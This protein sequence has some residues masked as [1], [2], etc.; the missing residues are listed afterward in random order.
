MADASHELRSP[1]AN[2]RAAIEVALTY[3]DSRPW[4]EVVSEVHAQT[5]RISRL[6]EDLLVLARARLGSWD[7][8]TKRSIWRR[9]RTGWPMTTERQHG[10]YG[11]SSAGSTR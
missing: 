9:L 11:Y 7:V 6:V 3:P 4:P 1:V 2:I 10:R 8:S 5:E